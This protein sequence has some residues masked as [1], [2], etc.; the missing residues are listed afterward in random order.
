M[1][2]NTPSYF[3]D[4]CKKQIDNFVVL[5]CKS[6]YGLVRATLS[7]MVGKLEFKELCEGCNNALA[8]TL[9]KLIDSARIPGD[10]DEHDNPELMEAD[11]E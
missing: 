3:C 9:E 8:E 5:S 4:I 10:Q 7:D 1:T 6:P 2:K 11:C